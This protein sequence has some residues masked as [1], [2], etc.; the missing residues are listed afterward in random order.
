MPLGNSKT[1][2]Q[3]GSIGSDVLAAGDLFTFIDVSDPTFASTGTNKKITSTKL[4]SEIIALAD[5]LN[6]I[7]GPKGDKGDTGNTGP[8]GL[9]GAKGDK[10]DTGASGT[11]NVDGTTILNT[12]DSLSVG[13]IAA[14]NIGENAVI[15]TKILDS[16]ITTAK[17]ANL[18]VTTDKIANLNV[19]T[20]KIA[21]ANITAPKLNGAQTGNA[22][23]FGV[24]AWCDFNATKNAAGVTNGD[25]TARFLTSGA[26]TNIA[27]VT[28]TASGKY[29]VLFSV[30]M[31]NATYAVIPSIAVGDDNSEDYQRVPKIY[32]KTTS[33]FGIAFYVGGLG[34]VAAN[35]VSGSFCV[36]A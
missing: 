6:L 16:N 10:G 13:V 11:S 17:I 2:T 19:T 30:A 12:D 8:Q 14:A 33:G 3:L 24:R 26:N 31:P 28:K 21:D 9:P 22:P 15:T 7:T 4:A 23:I 20:A 1:V 36:L 32:S 5:N 29:T 18:N 34:T 35:P 27:S 25:N